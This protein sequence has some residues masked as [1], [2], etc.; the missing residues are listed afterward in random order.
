MAT[1]FSIA[2]DLNKPEDF[3]KRVFA[4]LHAQSLAIAAALALA[5]EHS[6]AGDERALNIVHTKIRSL[7]ARERIMPI[8]GRDNHHAESCLN[9]I[10]SEA[11]KILKEEFPPRE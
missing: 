3:Q 8:N 5:A 4:E 2:Y 1:N 9:N 11:R 6:S 7:D 10:F